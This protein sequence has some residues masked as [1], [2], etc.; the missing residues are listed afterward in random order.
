MSICDILQKRLHLDE[1]TVYLCKAG[2]WLEINMF[3]SVAIINQ[4]HVRRAEEQQ[5]MLN[6]AIISKR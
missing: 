2:V 1:S 5:G 3:R 4:P 6:A